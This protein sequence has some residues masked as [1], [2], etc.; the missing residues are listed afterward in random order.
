VKFTPEDLAEIDRLTLVEEDRTIAPI[1][2][3]MK[4]ELHF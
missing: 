2:P 3:H 1:S 4:G